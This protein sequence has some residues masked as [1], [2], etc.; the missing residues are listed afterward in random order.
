MQLPSALWKSIG[1]FSGKGLRELRLAIE[2]NEKTG[3]APD[4]ARTAAVIYTHSL[5]AGSMTFIKTQAEAFTEHYPVYVGAHRVD[6]IELPDERTL[7]VNNGGPFG[8]LREALFR[9]WD[10]APKLISELRKHKPTVVHTHFGTCGPAGMTIANALDVPLVVTFH[11]QDATIKEEDVRKTF[12]GRDLL[13]KKDALIQRTDLFIAV[14]DYIKQC[15]LAKGYPDEKITVHR[16]GI[17]LDT[18]KPSGPEMSKP[19]VLFVGRFVEKKGIKYLLEA[20]DIL[21]RNDVEF[22]VVIV[23]SGPLE[24][25]LKADARRRRIPCTFTGFLGAD[26]IR[27]WIRRA[28]VVAVP[29][30]VASDGDSEGLPTILLESQAMETPVV[31]TYHSGIPEG[32]IEG[33]TAELV[34]EKD[35]ENFAIQLRTFLESTD[36]TS[37]FGQA[38]R[39]LMISQ[40]DM[41]KQNQKLEE[42]FHNL[43]TRQ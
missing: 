43:Q 7:L 35:A 42:I 24:N 34:A 18:F 6:G 22:E 32:V 2:K 17:D 30:C 29:S 20:A 27:S 3:S 5:L 9:K 38:G 4:G 40:F 16:N 23:G 8:V 19:I 41:R 25:E 36:K 28:R 14:S 33:E 1:R 12:R 15:L 26:E 31:A 21:M 10:Y 37:R 13:A 11:G 39:Q